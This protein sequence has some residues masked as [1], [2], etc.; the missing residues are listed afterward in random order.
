METFE[1]TDVPIDQRLLAFRS[2]VVPKVVRSRRGAIT[3]GIS[4][5]APHGI[6]PPN[7]VGDGI[8][9]FEVVGKG[10]GSD[11]IVVRWVTPST[12]SACGGI[13]KDRCSGE[14]GACVCEVECEYS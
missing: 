3:E 13:I 4:A 11:L 9:D 7:P 1:V 6:I 12:E 2:D 10:A 8:G 14:V 5:E